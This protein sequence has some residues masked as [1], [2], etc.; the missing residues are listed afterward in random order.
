MKNKVECWKTQWHLL[1]SLFLLTQFSILASA[2]W[3]PGNRQ[4]L[5]SSPP[6]RL[7][8][9]RR[10]G[11]HVVMD[12]G[13][14]NVTLSIPNGMVTG[15]QYNGIRNLLA[16]NNKE[17]RGYWDIVWSGN[18]TSGGMQDKLEGTTFKV[19]EQNENHVEL[20]FSRTWNN[21]S[22]LPLNTD[23]RY[24]MLRGS[25][26]F[27]SYGIFERL[28]G[29]PDVHIGQAR[30][31]FKL[32]KKYFHYMALSDDRQKFMANDDDRNRG[33][34]LDYQEAIHL[35]NPANPALKGEVDDKYQ[36]SC[37]NEDNRVHG[38]ISSNPHVGFWVISPSDE[39]RSG[40][41]V[42][43]ELTSH[44]GPTSLAMFFSGHY[45]GDM[46]LD[47]Q[48]GEPWK[49]VFGP[50]FIYLNSA[51]HN[52][53]HRTLW[54]DAKEQ[55]MIETKSWPYDFPLSK[56]F[57][58]ADQ[59]GTVTGRLLVHDRY[60]SRA[61]INASSAYVGLAPPGEKGSWEK[62]VKGYQF[63]TRTNDEG[64]FII[65]GIRAGTYNLFAWVPGFIG[66]YRY[67]FEV[68]VTQGSKIDL[69]NMVFEPPRNGPTLWE[70]GVPD[71]SAAEFFIPD[72]RPSVMTHLFLDRNNSEKFRQYGLWERYTDL[73]PN[74]DL[75][76]VVGTS[77]YKNDWF[78]A[79]VHRRV[80]DTY[81]PT[82]WRIFFSLPNIVPTGSYTLRLAL[83][84]ANIARLQV[85]MNSVY[86]TRAHF[87]TGLIGR[88][89][90]IARHGIHGLYWLYD[91][92]I[93]SYQLINGVNTLYLRQWGPPSP[94][95]GA[96]SPVACMRIAQ[97]YIF[98]T[99]KEKMKEFARSQKR[100]VKEYCIV[101]TS[102]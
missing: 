95:V 31:A 12:N 40:G 18:G 93:P 96:I 45:V 70:I 49:K 94:F 35:T 17:S 83:A 92:N 25:P 69:G 29:W 101:S 36:F 13:I 58:R 60:I 42:K 47:L 75:V 10:H 50:I 64:S 98:R 56:D 48:T 38:W 2:R 4:E 43:Q 57:P 59:R 61:Q 72:P 66:D 71:R 34:V 102:I 15:I 30:I 20:S 87:G 74:E 19:I 22:G 79:H 51:S 84:S 85:W 41:P 55:M 65:R 100:S 3:D 88:D 89:N 91:V 26:G 63:W 44:A 27:Y 6:V 39:F 16:N 68:T 52:E 5:T 77:D 21:D 28:K 32:Q 11:H 90:A 62:D 23:R 14:V 78:F 7:H 33:R 99:G 24:I 80:N 82:T 46:S 1:V 54:A 97:L 9:I 37:N 67:D 76:Y 73:H 8:Y 53:D 86:P 81:E